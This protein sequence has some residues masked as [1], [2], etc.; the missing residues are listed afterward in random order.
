MIIKNISIVLM[1]GSL[2]Y[3][4]S[5]LNYINNIRVKSGCSSLSL[6][7][8]LSYA[9]KKHAIY[10]ATNKL[11]GHKEF[12][13]KR[14]FYAKTPWQRIVK[15]GF[16][17]RAVVENIT[18][19]EP[20]YKAS[21]DKIMATVYHRLAFLDTKVDTIGFGRYKRV[22]VYDMSNNQLAKLCVSSQKKGLVSNICKNPN[23]TLSKDL[24]YRVLT[25]TK[26]KSRSIIFYPYNK[27]NKG[28]TA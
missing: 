9:A 20:S 3:A 6:S 12:S 27:Q 16:N 15:A 4:N 13:Y 2:V 19:Y 10:L 7:N 28:R 26:R 18:F 22:Y 8:K 1:L 24:F 14:N 17:T 21:I 5:T 23:K 25:S 11:F